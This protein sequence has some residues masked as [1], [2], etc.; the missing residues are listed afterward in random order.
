MKFRIPE[1]IYLRIHK[2]C[3]YPL[4]HNQTRIR[5]ANLST[6]SEMIRK[7][8]IIRT[9]NEPNNPEIITKHVPQKTP[10]SPQNS[11]RFRIRNSG[12]RAA[13]RLHISI[14]NQITIPN[15]TQP[16]HRITKRAWRK[17][18]RTYKATHT[19]SSISPTPRSLDQRHKQEKIQ[20]FTYHTYVHTLFS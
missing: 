9:A 1:I 10:H 19:A 6:F 18:R 16:Q 2:I 13:N 5:T 7:Q 17:N 12:F 15:S 8:T 14:Q 20:L 4:S 11:P 3:K